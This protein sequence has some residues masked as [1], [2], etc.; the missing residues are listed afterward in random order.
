MDFESDKLKETLSGWEKINKKRAEADAEKGEEK[1]PEKYEE[2]SLKCKECGKKFSE[3]E[4]AGHNTKTGH[5]DAKELGMEEYVPTVRE[6]QEKEFVV[7]VENKPVQGSGTKF[8]HV[9]CDAF[10]DFDNIKTMEKDIKKGRPI[11]LHCPECLQKF[12]LETKK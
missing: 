5:F 9:A 4:W 6:A 10:L 8:K 12:L 3:S 2:K 7:F 1:E 11:K